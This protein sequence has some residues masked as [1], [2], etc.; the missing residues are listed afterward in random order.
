MAIEYHLQIY[1]DEQNE[2][3]SVS[4]LDLRNATFAE[5]SVLKAEIEINLDS[6]NSKLKE[7]KEKSSR[8]L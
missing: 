3:K 5:L 2:M 4:K 8:N 7:I 6:I 1:K